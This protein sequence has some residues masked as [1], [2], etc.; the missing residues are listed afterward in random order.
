MNKK[1]ISY[2][3]I[4]TLINVS[5][6]LFRKYTFNFGLNIETLLNGQNN[7]DKD[8]NKEFDQ[9]KINDQFDDKLENAENVIKFKQISPSVVLMNEDGFL[10]SIIIIPSIGLEIF[11]VDK[12]VI[13]RIKK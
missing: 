1:D 13:E 9:I 7:N 3:Q 5:A 6:F 2:H 12:I 4:N 11:L 8:I 10:I